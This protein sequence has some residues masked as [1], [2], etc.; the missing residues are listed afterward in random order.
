MIGEYSNGYSPI[1][2]FIINI[3][4]EK[5]FKSPERILTEF[6][7]P[8]LIKPEEALIKC[9][10]DL[11]AKLD[12]IKTVNPNY[13]GSLT[14]YNLIY[15]YFSFEY[16]GY[17]SDINEYYS[18]SFEDCNIA[19]KNNIYHVKRDFFGKGEWPIIQVYLH[20][21]TIHPNAPFT[22]ITYNISR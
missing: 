10:E 3:M 6:K 15:K 21:F 13:T 9:Q 8:G 2:I 1:F 16:S 20:K 22:I 5:E 18:E 17:L 11:S 4:R 7:M 19:F 12:F 14:T